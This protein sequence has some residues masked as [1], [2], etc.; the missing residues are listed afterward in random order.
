MVFTF[1]K[2]RKAFTEEEK[3]K[4]RKAAMEFEKEMPNATILIMSGAGLDYDRVM[5][6][7]HEDYS[8]FVKFRKN[9]EHYLYFFSNSAFAF[10]NALFFFDSCLRESIKRSLSRSFSTIVFSYSFLGMTTQGV[11]IILPSLSIS[12][13]KWVSVIFGPNDTLFLEKLE[14]I[15]TACLILSIFRPSGQVLLIA[16]IKLQ[17]LTDFLCGQDHIQ[18]ISINF[19]SFLNSGSPV[20]SSQ[21]CFFAVFNGKYI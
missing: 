20:T 2:F 5:V 18:Y 15:I 9:P 17:F 6:S 12:R 10:K 16:L 4:V 3:R 13:K 11:N 19:S 7:F 14:C 1:F 21:L 8:S